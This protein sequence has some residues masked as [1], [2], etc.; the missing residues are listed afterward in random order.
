MGFLVADERLALPPPG[1]G[2]E[3]VSLD[4]ARESA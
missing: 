4:R 1:A 3:L 2:E